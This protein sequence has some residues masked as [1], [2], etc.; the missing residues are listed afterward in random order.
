MTRWGSN[1]RKSAPFVWTTPLRRKRRPITLA[2]ISKRVSREA[3]EAGQSPLS[4]VLTMLGRPYAVAGLCNRHKGMSQSRAYTMV[5][6][7]LPFCAL[8]TRHHV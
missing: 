5:S 6:P 3:G 7:Y 4:S 1:R 8:E 2:K